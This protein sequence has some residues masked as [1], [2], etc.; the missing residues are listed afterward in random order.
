MVLHKLF[1]SFSLTLLA[2]LIYWLYYTMRFTVD[3]K[4]SQ[5]H[6]IYIY[7]ALIQAVKHFKGPGVQM[8]V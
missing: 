4:S 2:F 3:P 5:R 1:Y 7:C 6:C 8:T